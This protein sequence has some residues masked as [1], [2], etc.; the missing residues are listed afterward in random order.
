[1]TSPPAFFNCQVVNN[2]ERLLSCARLGRR[3]ALGAVPDYHSL[4][5][6]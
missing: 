4:I 6:A 3:G 1:M 5:L 2:R